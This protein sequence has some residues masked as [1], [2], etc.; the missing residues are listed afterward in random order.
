MASRIHQVE[1]QCV[2][3]GPVLIRC[4]IARLCAA[5]SHRQN[6]ERRLDCAQYGSHLLFDAREETVRTLSI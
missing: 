4:E 2:H 3:L 6:I 5:G 1:Q